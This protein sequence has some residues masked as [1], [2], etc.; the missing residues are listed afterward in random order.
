MT[1]MST[2]SPDDETA[3]LYARYKRAL[4]TERELRDQVKAQAGADLLA[5]AKVAEL[6]KLTGM[7]PEVF[8]RI[9]RTV[10]AERLREPTVGKDA[11]PRAA[12]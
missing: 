11:K 12:E 9:A 10:G 2:W 4:E 6:A 8:R 7:T 3:R 5:G 1:P